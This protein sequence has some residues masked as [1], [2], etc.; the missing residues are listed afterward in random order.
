MR[1][2]YKPPGSDIFKT[3]CRGIVIPVNCVG[4]LGKGLAFEFKKRFPE[5]AERYRFYCSVNSIKPGDCCDYDL[6][7]EKIPITMATKGHWRHPSHF[8]WIEDG[9]RHLFTLSKA[10]A[11][12][13]VALPAIGCGCGALPWEGV[14]C[15]INSSVTAINNNGS[16]PD[17]TLEVYPPLDNHAI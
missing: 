9:L 7:N 3:D 6:E 14:R 11:I 2:I 15:A 16:L 4:V 17:F 10:C 1:T 8:H 13:S 5:A 12:Q